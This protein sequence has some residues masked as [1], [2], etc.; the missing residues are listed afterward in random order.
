MP[1]INPSTPDQILAAGRARELVILAQQREL[2][3]E[4]REIRRNRLR[5]LD[6]LSTPRPLLDAIEPRRV[7]IHNWREEL[8]SSLLAEHPGVY[9]VVC[10]SLD[11]APGLEPDVGDLL[12]A[13]PVAI[14]SALS[15]AARYSLRVALE[16]LV[17]REPLAREPLA[18]L[19]AE[20]QPRPCPP[21]QPA[22]TVGH[23]HGARTVPGTAKGGDA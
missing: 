5:V 7:L 19:L 21:G 11:I 8:L 17:E 22:S 12:N 10:K 6:D 9:E 20:L 15:V 18:A 16:S 1:V 4:L 2:A 23:P 13:D 3:R 14:R